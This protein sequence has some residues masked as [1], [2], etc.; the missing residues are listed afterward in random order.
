METRENLYYS[1][2]HEWVRVEGNLAYIGITDYA[3]DSLGS[4][5]YAEIPKKGKEIAKGQVLG[6]VESVK[7]ASDVFSPLSGTVV[8]GNEALVDAPEQINESPYESYLAVLNI[9]N[10]DELK[11]LL[12]Q[13]EYEEF[14]K[15]E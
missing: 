15:E 7:A 4:I 8:E 12:T 9:T 5:V 11:L 10:P 14:T 13:S 3:Q 1:K 2:D 6:V